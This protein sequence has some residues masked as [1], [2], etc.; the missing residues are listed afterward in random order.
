M[1]WGLLL[2]DSRRREEGVVGNG[3]ES[4]KVMVGWNERRGRSETQ[5]V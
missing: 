3:S 2:D 5:V 4:W 1:K